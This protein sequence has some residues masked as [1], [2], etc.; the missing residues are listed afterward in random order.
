M[1]PL[2]SKQI[3]IGTFLF[4]S[5]GAKMPC[6]I[7]NYHEQQTT[8]QPLWCIYGLFSFGATY[9][10]VIVRTGFACNSCILHVFL[11]QRILCHYA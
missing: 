7:V 5:V 1:L 9:V 6:I 10:A 2:S 8:E 11:C 4:N 3:Y